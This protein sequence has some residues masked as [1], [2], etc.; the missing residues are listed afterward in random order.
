MPE[1]NKR[2]TDEPNLT[3]LENTFKVCPRY[4]KHELTEDQME[5]IATR[6]AEKAVILNDVRFEQKIGRKV[7]N[8][9]YSLLGIFALGLFALS[10]K[11]GFIKF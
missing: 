3:E 2:F 10:I 5:A 6:A 7:I 9:F 4:D 11:L 1:Y 8:S